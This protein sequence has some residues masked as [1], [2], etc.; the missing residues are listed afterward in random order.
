MR[1]VH[2]NLQ[3]KDGRT[4]FWWA[5]A[6]GHTAVL[7]ELLANGHIEVHHEDV[8]Q[9]NALTRAVMNGR[10]EV[11]QLL[12]AKCQFDVSSQDKKRRTVLW[13]AAAKGHGTMLQQL[14][15]LCDKMTVNMKDEHGWDALTRAVYR[16]HRHA[17]H[18]LLASDTVNPDHSGKDQTPWWWAMKNKN[19]TM[20][21]ALM[22]APGKKRVDANTMCVGKRT[23]LSWAA[24]MGFEEIVRELLDRNPEA[25]L[26]DANKKTRQPLSW[27]AA[28]GRESVV[29]LLLETQDVNPNQADTKNRTPLWWAI[30]N[31]KVAIVQLLLDASGVE[32]NKKDDAGQTPLSLSA[33]LGRSEIVQK[34]LLHRGRLEIDAN[35]TDKHYQTPIS[36]AARNGRRNSVEQLLGVD[37]VD[38]NARDNFQRTPLMW[39]IIKGHFHVAKALILGEN[40]IVKLD[41]VDRKRRSALFW[42]AWAGDAATIS[43]LSGRQGVNCNERDRSGDTPLSIAIKR[44]YS[45]SAVQLLKSYEDIEINALYENGLTPLHLAA[46]YDDGETTDLLL[47]KGAELDGC[48]KFG[49]TPLFLACGVQGR[50]LETVSRFSANVKPL[51]REEYSA[52]SWLCDNNSNV[53]HQTKKGWTPLHNAC[54]KG[55]SAAVHWLLYFGA[56]IVNQDTLPE[57][58]QPLAL[59]SRHGDLEVVKELLKLPMAQ[60]KD[61]LSIP[62]LEEALRIASVNSHTKVHQLLQNHITEHSTIQNRL[63]CL[64]EGHLPRKP[65]SKIGAF[66]DHDQELFLSQ[67]VA[68]D[69]GPNSIWL[70][71]EPPTGGNKEYR[72]FIAVDNH[73][74][75]V[76]ARR[77]RRKRAPINPKSSWKDRIKARLV[78][79]KHRLT[80]TR[81]G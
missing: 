60:R 53:N 2:P 10:K 76:R 19:I 37:V 54:S 3:D 1:N 36:M 71:E 50:L 67:A 14:L 12:V 41:L 43:L 24:G 8:E 61:P 72:S 51:F 11:V 21:R 35:S 29:K 65:P 79:W 49:R 23:A 39:A 30:S 58:P 62:L 20:A 16:G 59:A 28:G 42:A 57:V 52:L 81:R 68:V 25:I 55:D 66:M 31:N 33:G 18:V 63:G 15:P 70:N 40:R 77:R 27:A 7:K 73:E 9:R 47:K 5:A 64:E 69:Q 46:Q 4:A 34:L 80:N 78:R 13:W 75:P 48:D 22:N 74:V 17:V 44:G 56:E 6:K 38:P 32:F 45:T 26:V